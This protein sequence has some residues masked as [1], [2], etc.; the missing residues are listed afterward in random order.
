MN[1]PGAFLL[2]HT[3]PRKSQREKPSS[4]EDTGKLRVILQ[5]PR[6]LNVIWLIKVT[7]P[8]RSLRIRLWSR[9]LR[10]ARVSWCC[11]VPN[12][13][14]DD[15]HFDI[16]LGCD[17]GNHDEHRGDQQKPLCQAVP[18]CRSSDP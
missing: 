14:A 2:G 11:L 1:K 16:G 9:D 12:M 3:L 15:S 18:A 8:R 4:Q 6:Q 7:L 13:L 17:L 5:S 10:S